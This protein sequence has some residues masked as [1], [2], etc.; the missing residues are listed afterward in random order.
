MMLILSCTLCSARLVANNEQV[1]E[2][3]LEILYNGTWGTVCIRGFDEK[4]ASVACRS[5]R[6]GLVNS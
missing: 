5:L 3:R 6:L 1:D 2:G 4:D